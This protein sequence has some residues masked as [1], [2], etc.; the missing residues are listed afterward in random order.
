M[1]VNYEWYFD[2]LVIS[3]MISNKKAYAD[4]FLAAEIGLKIEEDRLFWLSLRQE[5][6]KRDLD[7]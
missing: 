4:F 7:P 3:W 1:Y 2:R 5:H 6:S